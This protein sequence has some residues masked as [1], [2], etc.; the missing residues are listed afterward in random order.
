MRGD[1]RPDLLLL[2]SVAV[3]LGIGLLTV[4]SA[5]QAME[6]GDLFARQAV[7]VGVGLLALWG[8]Y[9]LSGRMVD[10]MA[11]FAWAAACL[12]LLLT[13]PL[14]SGP[15]GRWL[16]LGPLRVQPSEPAKA[17]LILIVAKRLVEM[18]R[19]RTRA[20]ELGVLAFVLPLVGLTWLQP[21]LGTAALMALLS[22]AMFMWAGYGP[23]WLFLLLSPL[24]AA[25]SSMHVVLWAVFTVLLVLV[26]IR[27]RLGFG[28]WLLFLGGNTAIA[29]V[30]PTIWKLLRPYQ[31]QRLITFINPAA[32][33]QGAGWN[34]IQS[35]VAV[36]SGGVT[37]Q[38]F[39]HGAQKGL[40]FLPARHTDFVF[41]VWAEETGLLGC[42]LLLGAFWVLIW[43]LV[44]IARRSVSP[45]SSLMVA[46]IA[47]Y[48]A[49]HLFVNVGMALGLMPVTGLPLTLVSYGGSSMVTSM[50]LLGLAL[51]AGVSWRVI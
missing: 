36:G 33:P 45:F 23:E 1:E 5:S 48:F 13:I 22:I 50:F 9:S 29:A 2:L 10:E 11:G 27:K 15:A 44:V 28:R 6:G 35:Q 16:V 21:D 17:V 43:R 20:G 24:L 40:A 39:L 25:L 47:A 14:G 34:I 12:M 37:G 19:K 26:L 31:Q 42:L 4:Y 41:S 49:L 46:G 32:D 38:G 3:I 8:G 18:R 30:T 7:W 51:R